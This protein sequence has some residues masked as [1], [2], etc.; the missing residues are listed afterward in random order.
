[1]STGGGRGEVWGY[2]L[3][4]LFEAGVP[5]VVMLT[6]LVYAPHF[7][8]AYM[9]PKTAVVHSMVPLLLGV[10]LVR[11]AVQGHLR[12]EKSP[13]Y[14]PFLVYLAVSLVTLARAQNPA[15]GGEVLLIQVWLFVFYVLVFHHFR[16]SGAAAGV[17]WT[18]VLT[19]LLVAVL[20][21]LQYNGVH[22]L[23]L[24]ERFGNL[25]VSTLGNPNF[26]AH[27]LEIVIPLTA[28][29]LAVRKRLWERAA[30]CVALGATGG[31]LLLTQSRAGWLAALA[32][33]LAL[34]FMRR[35]QIRWRTVLPLAVVVAAL[36]SPAA[37]LVLDNIHLERGGTLYDSA[38]RMAESS[39]ERALSSFDRNHFSISQRRIIWGDTLDLIR[40]HP[41]LGVGPGNYEFFL[42]AHRNVTRHRTWDELMGDRPHAPY[43]AH[44]EYLEA[45]A[46][47]G[48]FGLAAL[49]WLLGTMLWTGRRY[50]DAQ[51][52]P[53]ARAVTSGCLAGMVAA[54]VHSFFSFNLQD[55]T[56]AIH[57]WLLGGLLAAVNTRSSEHLVFSV[58]LG[59]WRR[60]LVS[61]V[62]AAA[63]LGGGY[64][65]LCI[66]LGDY[67][68]FQGQRKFLED[69]HPNR[70]I[71]AF[72]QAID[73]RAYDFRYHHMLGLVRLETGRYPQAERALQRSAELHPHNAPALRL[74]GR[75]LYWRGKGGEAVPVLR[76]AVQL[77]PLV[78]EA[79]PWLAL[80]YRQQG[81]HVQA[82]ETWKQ[83]LAFA[84]EDVGLL[85]SLGVEH[86]HA[87][88]LEEGAVVL[89]QAARLRAQDGLIQGNLGAVYL[90]MGRMEEAE[91]A[92]TRAVELSPEQAEW[93]LNLAQLYVRQDRLEKAATQAAQALR[94]EP[95]NEKVQTL[96]RLVHQRLQKG[97]P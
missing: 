78:A 28:G 59:R 75:A 74:L 40:A 26:V 94:L 17:L 30:L 83:A 67:Y 64:M 5:A 79:Y 89:E 69:R 87:G 88:Q 7:S 10:W 95:H 32:G 35:S 24:P 77:N 42:P 48:V 33:L 37:K 8:D 53:T 29:L 91:R 15:Q 81:E 76:R 72:Q 16:H 86:V 73:W 2:L 65:G 25:P 90:K 54:L 96:V 3:E 84:P 21:L 44:N 93:R 38:A 57:F 82:L 34:V 4:A 51:Q 14:L 70:A 97:E 61:M 49:L 18:I 20:G 80:A 62:A 31:H 27:Y 22:L 11:A 39:W 46:E 12:L 41:W 43:R 45:W 92:L 23:P 6:T 36:L 19:S 63:V 55:P 52:D 9:I 58:S 56:S 85:R 47:S 60:G 13:L 66:L 71:L 50:L 1:V 68:Y